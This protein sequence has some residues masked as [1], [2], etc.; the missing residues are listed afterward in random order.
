M[1]FAWDEAKAVANLTKH[2]V[3][4]D[5]ARTVFDNVMAVIFH[6]EEH[7]ADEHREII[8][9]HS[10]QNRVL[11]VSF[12]ERSNI[13]RIISARAATRREHKEY[14]ENALP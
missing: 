3:S 13:V 5:E 14:E 6:D 4:F 10:Q 2:G 8:I 11:L 12:T 1:E 9:G 7:S